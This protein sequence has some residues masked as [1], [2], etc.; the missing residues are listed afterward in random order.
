MLSKILLVS[1]TI[2]MTSATHAYPNVGDKVSWT[3]TLSTLNG[4]INPVKITK[5]V[6]SQDSKKNLWKVRIEATVGKEKTS[7][8]LELKELYSPTNF[9]SI[10]AECE[11][12][13]GTREKLT[14]PAG[15]YDTCKMS[16]T[17][18]DGTLVER[19]WGDIPF[20]V[21]SK[22]T[23]DTGKTPAPKSDLDS[24]IAGL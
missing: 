10:L 4:V 8:V 18:A 22:N 24:I 7:E 20:G 19:W 9:K 6:I 15:T 11:K 14:A 17:T 3:G 5:E 12:N 23:R 21:V 13:G 2:L 1:L 16:M